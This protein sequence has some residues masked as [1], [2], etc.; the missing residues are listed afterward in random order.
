MLCCHK[1][2]RVRIDV[3]NI[4]DR[5]LLGS[6]FICDR[7][8]HA[9]QG[10]AAG[11][12]RSTILMRLSGVPVS[13]ESSRPSRTG[14]D[15]FF[16]AKEA[17][18]QMTMTTGKKQSQYHQLSDVVARECHLNP[19]HSRG[20]A[21]K[22]TTSSKVST[23]YG[24]CRGR[25]LWCV[26]EGGADFVASDK[27]Q[28]TVVIDLTESYPLDASRHCSSRSES[29]APPWSGGAVTGSRGT[30]L[31]AASSPKLWPSRRLAEDPCSAQRPYLSGKLYLLT[32]CSPN[33]IT[34]LPSSFAVLQ[35]L[36]D[37][38]ISHALIRN[39]RWLSQ[40]KVYVRCTPVGEFRLASS[41]T[42][43]VHFSVTAPELNSLVIRYNF[44]DPPHDVN[45]GRVSTATATSMGTV[46]SSWHPL[47]KL[48]KRGPLHG[49]SAAGQRWTVRHQSEN[50]A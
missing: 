27:R 44:A 43:T 14:F 6:S 28:P 2:C 48:S 39:E 25:R 30:A 37:G 22:G 45:G 36:T 40:P 4:P 47:Y 41:A 32:G 12:L 33:E 18:V 24:P 13:L 9:A 10:A 50:A 46:E 42:A 31:G 21:L 38:C 29:T 5:S 17:F 23:Q 3:H 8:D 11:E 16:P 26:S 35:S 7:S 20:E 34:T 19:T 1:N 15:W 49:T